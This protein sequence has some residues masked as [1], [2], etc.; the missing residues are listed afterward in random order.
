[1]CVCVCV[2]VCMQCL[3]A[4]G[5]VVGMLFYRMSLT[6]AL[7]LHDDQRVRHN[8]MLIVSAT[9]AVI[10]LIAILVLTFV[11]HHATHATHPS[12]SLYS[13]LYVTT[14]RTQRTQRNATQ[15]TQ[16]VA[17]W[18]RVR[19]L[20]YGRWF[21]F[22]SGHYQVVTTWTG[23]CLRTGKPSWYTTNNQ[24]QLSLPSLQGR[25]IEY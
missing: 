5:V 10:N 8:A 17:R 15:R 25:W 6:T 23:D 7:Q 9:A 12:L 18:L 22:G 11:R 16:Q 19:T 1:V 24:G 14:Q 2:T 13:P 4:V 21:D 20:D 3:C